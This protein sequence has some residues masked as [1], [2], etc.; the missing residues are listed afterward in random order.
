ML[1]EGNRITAVGPGLRIAEGAQVID[2]RGMTRMALRCFSHA[3][4][5]VLPFPLTMT[6][7][8]GAPQGAFGI[9]RYPQGR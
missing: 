4:W 6:Q 9:S 7:V 1:V 5:Y 2:L 8:T 3:N